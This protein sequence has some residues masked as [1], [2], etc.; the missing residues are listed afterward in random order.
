[1]MRR[2]DV[3]ALIRHLSRFARLMRLHRPIGIWLL[4]WPTLWGLWI[5]SGGEPDQTIFI[6][7]V[8]GTIVMRTAGCV[9]NDVA[10]RHLDAEVERTADRP[11]ATGEVSVVEALVL[12]SGLLLIAAGLALTLNLEVLL[13]ALGGAAIAV[14]YPLMKRLI[15]APQLVLGIAFSWGVPMAYAAE[16]GGVSRDGW[17][18]FLASMIW[19]VAYDTLYAMVDREDDLNAG[20]HSTAI[21]FGDMD[22]LMIPGLQA[23]FFV[24]MGL[25]G[26]HAGLG[27]WYYG[28]LV[29]AAVFA[30]YQNWLIRD[31]DRLRCLEAFQNNAWFGGAVFTGILLDY[32]F[33]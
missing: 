12:F 9:I 25:V 31:R 26:E 18:L 5:A 22:R 13:F 14:V 19:V 6:V 4:L 15:A 17:L 33:A 3:P 29:V 32:L 10:D 11:L 27:N 23:L 2:P 21:M 1:M 24:C 20:V 28:G 30:G 16:R 7:F 8:V